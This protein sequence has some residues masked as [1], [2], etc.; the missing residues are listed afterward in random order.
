MLIVHK[1]YSNSNYN[2]KAIKLR[3]KFKLNI[4]RKIYNQSIGKLNI[5]KKSKIEHQYKYKPNIDRYIKED[6]YIDQT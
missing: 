5:D 6:K 2:R 1:W 3:S 4:D